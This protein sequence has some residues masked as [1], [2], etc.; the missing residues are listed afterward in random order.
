MSTAESVLSQI[1]TLVKDINVTTGGDY[2]DLYT[3]MNE[4]IHEYGSDDCPGGIHIRES[5]KFQGVLKS[6]YSATIIPDDGYVIDHDTVQITMVDSAGIN[7][8]I[9]SSAYSDGKITIDKVTGDLFIYAASTKSSSFAVSY[10]TAGVTMSNKPETVSAGSSYKTTIQCNSS[11]WSLY[12]GGI[13]VTMKGADITSD[14]C[15]LSEDFS[16][17]TISIG[18]ITGTLDIS[19]S[20]KNIATLLGYNS[21]RIGV[22]EYGLTVIGTGDGLATFGRDSSAGSSNYVYPIY[23]LN[24]PSDATTIMISTGEALT[25]TIEVI[26]NEGNNTDAGG[27]RILLTSDVESEWA[28]FNPGIHNYDRMVINLFA[29]EAYP[30][31]STIAKNMVI[32]YF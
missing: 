18:S 24:I 13:T 25:N 31:V 19:V 17:A 21:R 1:R 14:V 22:G 10:S 28:T 16:S 4:L 3:G 32:R 23:F 2:T 30:S 7:R 11:L 9:T 20:V 8:D 12:D 29:D 5:S 6:S 26:L 27:N 15:T